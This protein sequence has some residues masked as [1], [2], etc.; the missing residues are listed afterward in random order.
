ME[1]VSVA[2][3]VAEATGVHATFEPSA[4]LAHLVQLGAR[5]ETG[6]LASNVYVHSSLIARSAAESAGGAD[7]ANVTVS[8]NPITEQPGG[9]LEKNFHLHLG[10]RR[11]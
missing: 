3:I 10:T 9:Q 6:A 11:A 2:S 5:A 7:K 4:R 1:L 8:E